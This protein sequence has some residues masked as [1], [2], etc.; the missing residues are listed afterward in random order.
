VRG[1]AA[2]IAAALAI[3]VTAACTRVATENANGARAGNP[4]TVHGV[5]RIA[6]RQEP[7]NLNP[8]LGTQTVDTDISMFWAGYLFNW[9]DR[10]ELIP[11]LALRVPTLDNGDISRDG[12][13]ITYH[14]RRGVRWHD[15]APFGADDVIYT[16]HQVMNPQ[17]FVVSRFGYDLIERVDKVDD[18]T[19][20]VH[21]KH[22][23]A[24]FV[25]TFFTMASHPDCI[26]PKH[27]LVS[28]ASLNRAPYNNLPIGTGPF[29]VSSYEKGVR[30]QL[31]ANEHYW[32]G[33]PKLRRI[34]Y[35]IVP[36]DNT[37]LTLVRTHEIDFYY[38]ASETQAPSLRGIPGTRVV[39]SPFTRFADI[40]I[41][42]GV[43]ALR[44]RRVRQALAYATDRAALVEK[45]THGI[46]QPG[47]SDQPSFFW[48]YDARVKRYTYDPKRAAAMLDAAGWRVGNGGIREKDGQS[49]RLTM[50]GFTGSAT[51]NES[52][53]L[54]QQEW[55]QVG[56]DV[57]IKNFSSAQL[58]ATLGTGGIEQSG[59]FDVA[60]ENWANGTDPDDSILFACTM[61]PPVGWNI[62]HLCSRELDAAERTALSSNDRA[63]RKAAYDRVQEIVAEELPIIVLWY[64][65][66][67]DVINSDFTGYRPAHAVTPFWNTWEW[68]T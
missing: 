66:E 1:A 58:Y 45:V 30:V 10:D 8:L 29:R 25:A 57:A 3:V 60:F 44:D 62:Y 47:D 2:A 11:E 43:A 35:R 31:V 24:P 22:A 63:V 17:N 52:Q 48:A 33:P 34:E 32:R 12:R 59:K 38:R 14:L 50:V 61:A 6:G 13:T 55:R 67:F 27:L 54:L 26:L 20:V 49:L 7:D 64:Q 19:V 68:S 51:V 4:W 41:N 9:S 21:L 16:W 39:L 18:A 42:A 65:R 53:A 15:G 23:F 46:A 56:V 5:L 40:G 36:N 37:I 28:F